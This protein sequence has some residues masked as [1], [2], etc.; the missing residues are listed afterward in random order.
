MS[1]SVSDLRDRAA[2]ELDL[3]DAI[4]AVETRRDLSQLFRGAGPVGRRQREAELQELELAPR[5]GRHVDVVEG[6]SPAFAYFTP[7][8]V[9]RASMFATSQSVS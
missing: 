3:A 2:F 6:R 8:S 5:V 1:S 9:M 7:S 4:G